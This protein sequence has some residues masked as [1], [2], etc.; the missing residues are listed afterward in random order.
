VTAALIAGIAAPIESANSV[1]KAAT[2]NTARLPVL[3]R[4]NIPT[5][6]TIGKLKN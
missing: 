6:I 2:R 5:Y 1:T 4:G 3:D